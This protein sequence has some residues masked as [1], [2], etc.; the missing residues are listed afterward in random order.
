MIYLLEDDQNIR[1]FTVYAVRNSG[2]EIEGFSLPSAFR[3]AVA[4]RIPELVL[5][6]IMLP[7]E[8]GLSVLRRLRQD[9]A[10]ARLPIMMLSARSTEYDKVLGLD[11]GADDYLA[12]PFGVME[13]LSRIRALLRRTEKQSAGD[14]LSGGGIQLDEARH[15]VLAEG[16]EI[17]LTGKEFDLLA[18][19]MRNQGIVLSRDRILESV[20]GYDY[21]GESRTVDVHIRTLRAKLGDAGNSIDTVR[22]VGYRFHVSNN[23]SGEAT[24]TE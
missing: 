22:G 13:L 23:D 7:E 19:L 1:D 16:S 6:D 15:R 11:S 8:D 21:A 20:W 2:Y 18:M 14:V 3:A 4:E 10:T 9:P 12:K 17:G 5:L 24:E